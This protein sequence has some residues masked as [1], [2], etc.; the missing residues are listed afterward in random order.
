MKRKSRQ[1]DPFLWKMAAALLALAVAFPLSLG[2]QPDDALATESAW[3]IELRQQMTRV[4]EVGFRLDLAAAP[5]CEQTAAG[6]GLTVDYIGAYEG[7]SRADVARLLHLGELP[8][9]AAVAS[10]GPA[11]QA[12]IVPGDE[13]L[14]I[15]GRETRDLQT[16]APEPA[17]FAD[18]IE[19]LLSA[20]PIGQ[21]IRLTL[22]RNGKS[23]LVTVVPIRVCAARF[24]IKTGEGIDAFGDGRNVAIGFELAKFTRSDDELALVAGHELAHIA[25]RRSGHGSLKTRRAREDRADVLGAQIAIC[26]GYDLERGL[27]FW[28]RYNKHDWLRFF[29]MPTHRSVPARIKLIASEATGGKCPPASIVPRPSANTAGVMLIPHSEATP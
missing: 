7:A 1:K 3:P 6:T 28:T 2:F 22:L 11:A 24:V 18:Y 8:Q 4:T 15:D 13:I 21:S 12:G 16:A 14:A 20:T 27:D 25:E 29:R 23:H 10:G 19:N 26:A 17:L 9:I 5:L